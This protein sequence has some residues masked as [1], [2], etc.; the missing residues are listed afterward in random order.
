M[1]SSV[2]SILLIVAMLALLFFMF[3]SGKKREREAAEMRNSLQ[4]GDEI[5]TIGGIVGKIVSLREETVVIETTKDKTHIRFLRS[6]VSRVDV[7][8]EDSV[9]PA[10]KD[11]PAE[12][13]KGKKGGKKPSP[14]PAPAAIPASTETETAEET[15]NAVTTETEVSVAD[16]QPSDDIPEAMPAPKA[17]G[18]DNE[19]ADKNA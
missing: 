9:A 10:P 4:V 7:R 13:P 12:A 2:T 1:P 3:R 16:E 11:A 8:A 6:A 5:T 15:A 14:K 18:T 19:S 17:A